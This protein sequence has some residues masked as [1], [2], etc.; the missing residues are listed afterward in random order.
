MRQGHSRI[1]PRFDKLI[2]SLRTAIENGEGVLDKQATSFDD[3]FDAFRL[4]MK[5]Y[6]MLSIKWAKLKKGMEIKL[7]TVQEILE[8]T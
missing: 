2:I 6:E 3:V 8:M 5:F 1:D 4:A 7:I